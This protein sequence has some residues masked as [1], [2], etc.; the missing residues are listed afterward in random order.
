MIYFNDFS[1]KETTIHH[2]GYKNRI[3][4]TSELMMLPQLLFQYFSAIAVI[5]VRFLLLV[6][7][8]DFLLN[9]GDV[10][11]YFLNVAFKLFEH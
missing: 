6:E 11:F 2:S 10:V 9:L 7:Q 4:T 1:K 5:R 3:G 8:R